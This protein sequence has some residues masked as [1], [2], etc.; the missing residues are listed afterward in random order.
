[1]KNGSKANLEQIQKNKCFIKHINIRTTENIV[2]QLAHPTKH[3]INRAE[4]IIII[5]LLSI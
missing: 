3:N 5:L 4:N 2:A 1:M